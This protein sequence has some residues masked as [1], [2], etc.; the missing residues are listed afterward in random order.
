MFRLNVAAQQ[1]D[2]CINRGMF[3]LS[4]KPSIKAGEILLLQLKKADWHARGSVGGRIRHA[5][6]FQR[7]EYDATGEISRRHWP[8]ADKI[9]PWIIYSSAVLDVQPFS[10]EELPLRRE[11]HYQAQANP[12]RID[13]EDEDLVLPYIKWPSIKPHIIAD[14]SLNWYT[15][16]TPDEI[17]IIEQFSVD[18]AMKKAKEWFP[19]AKIEVMPRNNPG[20]DILVTENGKVIRYI[21]V[22][23]TKTD[24]PIF[25]LTENERQFSANNSAIYTILVVWE[26]DLVNGTCSL[27][28]HDGE[29]PVGKILHP[30][31]YVG[32]LS[33]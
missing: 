24:K 16:A 9:W 11:S 27:A 23:G 4:N 17:A 28:R 21:E 13:S 25:N 15:P 6:V 12:V 31:R 22:K 8:N 20:F 1:L 2:E 19:N 18:Y 33:S 3:A 32:K 26:I 5:L 30:E 10:L 14:Q 7:A 29:I